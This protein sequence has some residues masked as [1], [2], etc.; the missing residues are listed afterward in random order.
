MTCGTPSHRAS[1][2][3]EITHGDRLSS[4]RFFDFSPS[5]KEFKRTLLAHLGAQSLE[6]S[7]LLVALAQ[8][9]GREPLVPRHLLHAFVPGSRR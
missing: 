3:L 6:Q 9:R 7:A 8:A 4:R 1:R 2:N 5:E